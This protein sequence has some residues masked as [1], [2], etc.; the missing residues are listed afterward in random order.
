MARQIGTGRLPPV[1]ELP[2]SG[3]VRIGDIVAVAGQAGF[4]V[5]GTLLDGIEAQTRRTLEIIH[6][7]LEGIGA[8]MADV[9]MMRVYLVNKSDF[10][11]MNDV[12][13]EFF[14]EP[15]PARTTVFPNLYGDILIEIDALAVLTS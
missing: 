7:Q 10:Q 13:A 6:G 5:E 4:D 15:Y 9:I 14:E 3:A 2:I 8:S 1:L 12:Y 11:A